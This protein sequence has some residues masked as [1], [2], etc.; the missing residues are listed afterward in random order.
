MKEFI[1]KF[2]KGGQ[3]GVKST[4][5]LLK[6]LENNFNL[7]SIPEAAIDEL[8]ELTEVAEE[9]SKIALV[10]LL[11]LLVLN[12][13]QAKYVATKHWELVDACMIQ[14]LQMQDLSDASARIMQNY[15]RISLQLLTNFFSTQ[16][17]KDLMRQPERG[18]ATV[19][20]CIFS[21]GSLSP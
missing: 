20:F 18:H 14:Y 17:G 10:D 1:I 12:D 13:N 19:E 15:H 2:A 4:D 9:K 21:L 7:Q 8:V 5:N 11:R 16:S 6:W 3:S